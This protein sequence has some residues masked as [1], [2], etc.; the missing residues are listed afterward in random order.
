MFFGF[1]VLKSII[2][3]K[4][5]TKS[6]KALNI[7]TSESLS[8]FKPWPYLKC[9]LVPLLS[10]RFC[11]ALLESGLCGLLLLGKHILKVLS[12]LRFY[13]NTFWLDWNLL[14]F[15]NHS[16]HFWIFSSFSVYL[17][18]LSLFLFLNFLFS[19]SLKICESV[20]KN[21]VTVCTWCGPLQTFVQ[22]H[23]KRVFLPT[24]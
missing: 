20:P 12:T 7:G 24:L 16:C 6:K 8:Y 19:D 11:P 4:K 2:L 15:W 14:L 3:A 1:E 18:L 21:L 23:E 17:D 13:S 9:S 22:K 10:S 5:C